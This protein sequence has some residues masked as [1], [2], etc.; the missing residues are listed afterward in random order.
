MNL[1]PWIGRRLVCFCEY[2]NNFPDHLGTEVKEMLSRTDEDSFWEYSDRFRK[3][4]SPRA[5]RLPEV[6]ARIERRFE[7][8]TLLPRESEMLAKF[9][10]NLKAIDDTRTGELGALVLCN[11][12]VGRYVRGSVVHEKFNGRVSLGTLL[13]SHICWSEGGASHMGYS[14][15]SVCAGRWA[16]HR[17]EITTIEKMRPEVKWKDVSKVYVSHLKEIWDDKGW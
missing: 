7:T 12:T 4:V 6:V 13:L 15:H 5:G 11:L 2:T 16:G 14:R 3:R 9:V 1:S 17:F 8:V 10:A